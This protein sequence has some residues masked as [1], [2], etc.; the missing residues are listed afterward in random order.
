MKKHLLFNQSFG[1]E[2]SPNQTGETLTRENRIGLMSYL[3]RTLMLLFAVLMMS[4]ANIGMAWGET[5]S[6]SITSP[7]NNS[8]TDN[9]ITVTHSSRQSKTFNGVASTTVYK[10]DGSNPIS[11]TSTT[12]NITKLVFEAC[13]SNSGTSLAKSC[14][15]T[16]SEDG[17][18]Y[19]PLTSIVNVSGGTG[20]TATSTSGIYISGYSGK[21]EVTVT[22]H[23]A[24]RYIKIEKDGQETWVNVVKVYTESNQTITW[25]NGGHS[26]AP[27]SPT[28]AAGLVMPR[29]HTTEYVHV[30]WKANATT[31]VNGVAT[32]ANILIPIGAA[33]QLT[34]ATTLTAQWEEADCTGLIF[35]MFMHAVATKKSLTGHETIDISNYADISKGAEVFLTNTSSSAYGEITNSSNGYSGY[36]SFKNNAVYLKL[37]L[38]C[39]LQTNDVLSF[40]TGSGD[41]QVYITS[42]T[43]RSSTYVSTSNSWTVPAAFNGVS[44]IYIWAGS[45]TSANIRTLA[46]IRP[47]S[48]PS[49]SPDDAGTSGTITFEDWKSLSTAT[50]YWKDG[51]KFYQYSGTT[52]V[53][54]SH[55]YFL[56]A[57]TVPS[58]YAGLRS[59]K[60]WG[61][62]NLSGL[63]TFAHHALGI[64]VTSPSQ[65]EIIL[66]NNKK[67][68]A[69]LTTLFIKKDNVDYKTGYAGGTYAGGTDIKSDAS[70]T[71]LESGNGRYKI[72]LD[73]DAADLASSNPYIVKLGASGSSAPA[74]FCYESVTVT[75]I[76]SCTDPG[77]ATSLTSTAATGTSLTLGW[78][79]GSNASSYKVSL[80]TDADCTV[81]ASSTEGNDYA[82]NT[83]SVTYTGLSL[84][85][86]YY[87]KVQSVGDGSSYCEDGP[88]SSA[89]GTVKTGVC[90]DYSFHYG[91]E[92]ADDWT[93]TCF[94]QV[95]ATSEWEVTD[96]TIPSKPN[97]YVGKYGF[98]YNDG[99][100]YEN[101]KSH[102][103]AWSDL[104]FAASQGNGSGTRPKVG[105]ATGATGRIRIYNNSSWNNLFASFEPDGY[106]LKFGSS[107][108]DTFEADGSV[109]H[110]YWSSSL[111]TYSSSNA[112]DLVSVG[113]IDANNDFV[114]TN[115]TEGMKHIF[116]NTGGTDYWSKDNITNF[117][118][119]NETGKSWTCL[120]TKVPGEDYLYEG[121]V[122]STCTQVI[123]ARL[124]SSDLKW[125]NNDSDGSNTNVYNQTG[126]WIIP[127]NT[128]MFTISSWSSGSWSAYT[129]SGKFRM[130]DNST[131]KNWYVHFYPHN[132]LS[133]DGNGGTGSVASQ[134]V[135]ADADSKTVT[136]SANG[137]TRSGWEFT[138]WNTEKHGKGTAYA[139]GD[140]I[141]VTEDIKLYAQWERTVYLKSDLSWWYDKNGDDDAW[142]SIYY[143]DSSDDSNKGWLEMELADCETNVYK[144]T[145]PGNGYNNIIFVRKTTDQDL[146]WDNV[147]NQSVNI[148]YPT[149]NPKYT[150][151]SQISGGDDNGK[152]T[153]SWG[154]YSV[155]TFTISYN[156]GTNG[157]GTK[158]NES[159]TCSVDFTLPGGTFTYDGHS[160]DG[161]ATSDGGTKAYN[162]SGSYT[163]N[164][165][166]TFYPHWKCN[167]PEISCSSGTVTIT[168]PSGTT[169]YYTTTTDGSEPADPT[170]SSSEY[171]PESK[172]TIS[173]DTKI[174]AIAI[175]DGCTSSEIASEDLEY[176]NT[177]TV[178]YTTT[179]ST[180]GSAPTDSNS[181][182]TSGSTVTVLG[183][184]GSLV[185]TGNVFLG[186]SDGSGNNYAPGETFTISSNTTLSPIWKDGTSA[187]VTYTMAVGNKAWS[188]SGSSNETTGI[189][190]A[191]VTITDTNAGIDG[192]GT[193]S[194]DK[195]RTSKLAIKTG[196]N[197]ATYDSPTNYILYNFSVASGYAFT[198]SNITIKIANVGS[199]SANNIKYKAV[200]SDESSHSISTT[201]ICTTGDGTIETFHLYNEEGVAFDGNVSLKL[202]AWTIENISS[203]GSNYRL[204]TP[205]TIAGV[206]ESTCSTPAD[207]DGLAVGSITS[208]GATFTITDDESP[209]SYEIY[210][211]TSSTAPTSGTAASA[212]TTSKTKAVTG[213]DP[214]TTYY[215]WV[216]AVCNASYKSDWVALTEST[217][218]TEAISLPATLDKSN[219]TAVSDDTYWSDDNTYYDYGSTDA[220]NT[221][222]YQD[223]KVYVI[224]CTYEVS[225][226]MGTSGDGGGTQ[227]GLQLLDAEEK[228]I[229]S[230]NSIQVWSTTS[231]TYEA[232][233][234]LSSISE[235]TYT[236]RVKNIY[237]W[238]QPKLKSLTLDASIYTIT[239]D[240]N[241]GTCG[242]ESETVC[243]GG[244]TL[245]IPT[246][247]GYACI[248]WYNSSDVKQGDAG[249]DY[250]PDNDITLYAHW[251]A[252]PTV[253][254]LEIDYTNATATS[255]PL[256]W[257]IPGKIDLSTAS[258]DDSDPDYFIS[259]QKPA[260]SKSYDSSSEELTVT[261]TATQWAQ[262]GVA[263]P[264]AETNLESVTYEYKGHHVFPAVVKSDGST[265]YWDYDIV[266]TAD[267]WTKV[268]R[269]PSRIYSNAGTV[270]PLPTAKAITFCA[271]PNEDKTDES[272]YIRN[273]FYHLQGQ[274]DVDHVV[275]MR[276]EGSAA[277]DTTDASATKL[278]SGKKSHFTDNTAVAGKAYYYTV[279]T[280]HASGVVSTGVSEHLTIYTITYDKG[281]NGAGTIADGKKTG[282][283]DFTL[284]GTRFTR[285]HYIQD[286]W[287]ELDGGA[288]VYEMSGTYS[289]DDDITLYPHWV[290]LDLHQ[291]GVYE[292]PESLGGYGRPLKNIS[293]HDYEVYFM[294]QDTVDETNHGALYAG[295]KE[296]KISLGKEIFKEAAANTEIKGDG[297]MAFNMASSRGGSSSAR[298]GSAASGSEFFIADGDNSDG[299][300]DSRYAEILSGNYI[301]FRVSGYDQFSFY[302]GDYNASDQFIVKIDGIT[303]SYT[304]NYS[305][306]RNIFRFD[307][308]TGEHLIEITANGTGEH[309]CKFRGFSLR[310]PDVTRYTVSAESN[311]DS[312]GA[313]SASSVTN[314]RSGSTLYVSSNTFTVN[315]TTITATPESNTAEY[316][317]AFNNWTIDSSPVT[318]TATISAATTVTANFTQTTNSYSLSWSTDGDDLTGDY[319]SG[320]VAY[321]TSITEPNTP[322]KTGYTFDAWSPAFTGTMPAAN[323]EY[324]A[325]WT[326]NNYTLTWDFG[327]GSTS[328]DDYT[329]GSVA[330][331]T[332]LDYPASN[333]MSKSGY[334]FAGWST[335]AST[336]PAE[337]LTL[338]AQWAERFTVTYNPMEG[339]VTPTSTIGSSVNPVTLPTPTHAS[340]SFL[341]WYNTAGTKVGDADEEYTPTAN[342]TLYAKWQGDCAGGGGGSTTVFSL[343]SITGVGSGLTTSAK[344]VGAYY[345][346]SSYCT[347]NSLSDGVYVGGC[348][349]S[350]SFSNRNLGYESTY[351][352]WSFG[353]NTI[354]LALYSATGFKAGDV[355]TM[356]V[357]TS[358]TQSPAFAKASASTL[359]D[360]KNTDYNYY[361]TYH[362]TMS[363]ETAPASG[364]SYTYTGTLPKGFVS[365][366]W[367]IVYRPGQTFK[368]QSITV[369]RPGSTCYTVTYDGNGATSGYV[370]DPIAYEED[371]DPRVLS[372]GFTRTGYEFVGWNT[373]EDG[374]GTP[375]AE[376]ATITDIDDDV[377]LYAQWRVLIDAN[378]A[379]FADYTSVG[380]T[381]DVRVANGATLTITANK[382]IHDLI[383]EPGATLS[384]T[385]GAALSVNSLSL[386]GGWTT[387]NEE[388]KY[389]MP[390]VYISSTSSLTKISS[391]VNF[392]IS[393]DKRNYYPFA[394]PFE[395]AV[396]SVDYVNTTL[397]SAS[398]YGT[399]YVILEYDGAGRAAN[400]AVDANWTQVASD[401]TLT[402]GKGYILTAVPV[403]K[404][405][406]THAA[407]RFPMTVDDAWTTAGELGTA[408]ISDKEV[409]KN[410]IEVTAYVKAEG[411]TAKAN[412]GWN[413]LGIPYMSCY[414][415][416]A[417]M[418]TGDGAAAIMQGKID[419]KTNKFDDKDEIRYVSVP[420]HDFSE[421]LQYNI[422]D[423]ATKLLPGWCFFVQVETT[424]NLTYAVTN[425]ETSSDLPIYAPKREQEMPTVKTGIIL[426]S[427][428]ASDKTTILVS[429]KYSVTDYEINADLEKM[430]GNAYTL[431]TYSLMGT[432]RLAY[433][434]MSNAEARNVIPI[435]YRAP[436][437]GEYTFAINPRYAENFEHVN[438]IDYETGFVTD[439]LQSTY[440]FATERTQND[441]RFA[442]NI[443]RRQDTTTDIGNGEE[444][445]GERTNGVQKV[446]INDKLY[447]IVDGRMYDAKGVMVK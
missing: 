418:Y 168:V 206:T 98:F 145:L 388:E 284:T 346:A 422:V 125:K 393:V 204:G 33:I 358:N 175:Q 270:S 268:T 329:T 153:G 302:G 231:K 108:Y 211:S 235:G 38:C 362:L 183:N 69:N 326:I 355:V 439:L 229:A 186:W 356:V 375:Y 443:V 74:L 89:S 61:S 76:V 296:K 320:T 28:S 215:A 374:S 202:W 57:T 350:G 369:T 36:V 387:I 237:A 171:D 267:D 167:T 101:A 247:A 371:D 199:S 150:I 377:T 70:I 416:G 408:T 62:Y 364:N 312:Y 83:N 246:K 104:F 365:S 240:A 134:S 438:L 266:T 159:K 144:A 238:A 244:V 224:P 410:V 386:H 441:E 82:V 115:N 323:T 185:K 105:A 156:K 30:G 143:W 34:A 210:Y 136:V 226:V 118:L 44:T 32:D 324:V 176:V 13:Y 342:I 413:L 396:S 327:G 45:N 40:T 419:I 53:S 236:L 318:T 429:D 309:Y 379:N 227:W 139:A 97:W 442:I 189:P 331:G 234:N 311:N 359:D 223:W 65:I 265:L 392:D 382:T 261:Y 370:N 109:D 151:T 426:S 353:Q 399:H 214:S 273:V 100:N 316:S 361:S 428:T 260:N 58:Y 66:S 340:F 385:S 124:K 142:F 12:Q 64:S 135:K 188:A 8:I 126:T 330:Y 433:N 332:T 200:L 1:T 84:N 293:S 436:A 147:N 241:G 172:P 212:T 130:W 368:M 272:F 87:F 102:T 93:T 435:G 111:Y 99:M 71:C 163:T 181:P 395:V 427:E 424:G 259:S 315:G 345:D 174:K 56:I 67:D 106:K 425:Q 16:V 243:G 128:N 191:G 49:T 173:E 376:D 2:G 81:E 179:E 248:G 381:D 157:T 319:T 24:Y 306:N 26:T 155:P 149:T 290:N 37:D 95:G 17:S 390:R 251:A 55:D 85:S 232:K 116:L 180:S 54:L 68:D 75:P 409:T 348:A 177:Y 383:I 7:N 253:S 41:N 341:G 213:L 380:S 447:I 276:K 131:D 60:N 357:G 440:T 201:Y 29:L 281:A 110:C 182:Y 280:V 209:A 343:T 283:I 328:D 398:I 219:V 96:F 414:Q 21:T 403:A 158:D 63:V 404:Y 129:K 285:D 373:E 254:D 6:V 23:S 445:N 72:T 294:T 4:I 303:Q 230:Y 207:P 256:S 196:A 421:Y 321:G 367:L 225:V 289:T 42:S 401:A 112:G 15:V 127:A 292:K 335:D 80:F 278:Y 344:D 372:N 122:P 288:K 132:V 11:I 91:T 412:K 378:N 363:S 184:T 51:I 313:V 133:Y 107:T 300:K 59:G 19:Y 420:T 103:D 307:I 138:G 178:T 308:S 148:S 400:G 222:R 384:I 233:W 286:G 275:L 258:F 277:T 228:E 337:A 193:G 162:L 305:N 351:N 154:T 411:E 46:I 194:D 120:M 119:W 252:M 269:T 432:T 336:M 20:T 406:G 22:F 160:Q 291:P 73:V 78:T 304:H 146:D 88:W 117:G 255:I 333:T 113:I 140:D 437:D 161:W 220:T 274:A 187:T 339:S 391:T 92:N 114:S 310:L 423:E 242:T 334:D 90:N 9:N 203:G 322:T 347:L 389:D 164:V 407:I 86:T 354:Y 197:G 141:D 152:V 94:T 431:A 218:E 366:N 35:S 271:N 39:P 249:G 317:Y 394:V 208:S 195:A 262:K 137:F 170:S 47:G 405:T 444:V 397:A 264:F 295:P 43:T 360:L 14:K 314:V 25:N 79:A 417:D 192:N 352:A 301:R 349:N 245:P 48:S 250:E 221:S 5:L 190:N 415:T 325:Q 299:A 216:R 123:F 430:F 257:T 338:T 31:R 205:L 52:G 298:I 287:S 239:Y 263:L 282:Q 10:V 279:F 27:T 50:N 165:A 434:A 77:V 18:T 198:P 3:R 446:I 166:Q 121:W 297:W 217:F 169:V 402:P